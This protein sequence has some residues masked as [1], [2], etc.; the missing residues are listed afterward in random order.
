M[1][2]DKLDELGQI[3][4]RH[5]ADSGFESDGMDSAEWRAALTMLATR[6]HTDRATL[7]ALLDAA[8]ADAVMSVLSAIAED[9][10]SV[11]ACANANYTSHAY[12]ENDDGE[13]EPFE[14]IADDWKD[15][16]RKMARAVLRT[17]LE[18]AKEQQG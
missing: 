3:R 4:A 9:G 8:R 10:A 7:L 12:V 1:D 11:E 2:A 13:T 16:H 18:R 14:N 15:V 5:E 17:L 6:A